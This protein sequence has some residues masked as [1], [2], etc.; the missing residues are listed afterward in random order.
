M[1]ADLPG[2]KIPLLH[3]WPGWWS[4]VELHRNDLPEGRTLYIDLD[5]TVVSSLKPVWGIEGDLVMFDNRMR[6]RLDRTKRDSQREV[7]NYQAGIMLFDP[8]STYESFYLRFLEDP[9]FYM[10]KYRSEQDLMGE[11]LPNQPKFP[12]NWMMK[13]AAVLERKRHPKTIF[14]TG[15]AKKYNFRDYGTD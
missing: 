10:H 3:N 11:W 13:L 7:Y 12:D 1:E 15:N 5:T 6:I 8:G 4:K 9:D 2:T 14:V